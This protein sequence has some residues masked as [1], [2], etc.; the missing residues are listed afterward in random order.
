MRILRHLEEHPDGMAR[1]CF[2]E[3]ITAGTLVVSADG[4]QVLL[5]LHA[6]AQRWFAFGGHCEPADQTLADVAHRE[7]LEESGLTELQFD[8]IPAQLDAH[9]VPFC[10]PRGTVTHLD[11]RYVA[12]APRSARHAASE[13]SLDVRW[14]PI[15]ALPE[16]LED[17]M[18]ALIALARA[19]VC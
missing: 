8:P 14:W 19:R 16:G 10:D 12:V 17:D 3:H 7:A 15:D 13:E 2:P 4:S 11:V 6:K 9:P 18:H 1:E 5:N